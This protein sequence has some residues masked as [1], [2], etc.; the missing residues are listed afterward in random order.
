MSGFEQLPGA[1]NEGA[2]LAPQT[3]EQTA[4]EGEKLA[5]EQALGLVLTDVS[6]A[7]R[8][9]TG[10]GL[11][12]VVEPERRRLPRVRAS[13]DVAELGQAARQSEYAADSGSD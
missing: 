8:F 13:K 6:L 2:A 4:F 3:A 7:E 10:K 12:C 11:A 5:D 9:V 1:V